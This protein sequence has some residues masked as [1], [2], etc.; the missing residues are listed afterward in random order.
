MPAI[1]FISCFIYYYTQ[2]D[3]VTLTF[4]FYTIANKI[5][6][7]KFFFHFS[8]AWCDGL[9][10]RSVCV[11]F[12]IYRVVDSTSYVC[13]YYVCV[14]EVTRRRCKLTRWVL[15]CYWDIIRETRLKK[16][17]IKKKEGGKIEKKKKKKLAPSLCVSRT[18]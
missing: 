2:R 17:K 6:K 8:F 13:I 10:G 14:C 4:L 11:T 5:F 12:L 15:H 7:N 18:K 1:V 9:L 16:K 3:C